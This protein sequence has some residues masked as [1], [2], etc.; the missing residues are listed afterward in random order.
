MK[1]LVPMLCLFFACPGFANEAA[2]QAQL[3]E[4]QKVTDALGEPD[5]E[6]Q[7][8][9]YAVQIARSTTQSLATQFSSGNFQSMQA[10]I[11][12]SS[13]QLAAL[14]N[15]FR[16]ALN[17]FNIELEKHLQELNEARIEEL[18]D[19]FARLRDEIIAAKKP[20][21]LDPLLEEIS[22]RSTDRSYGSGKLNQE[23]SNLQ[24]KVSQ[25]SAIVSEWQNYLMAES[26]N[27]GPACKRALE[28][29]SRY[30][31]SN[32]LIPR[33]HVLRLLNPQVSVPAPTPPKPEKGADP[34]SAADAEAFTPFPEIEKALERGGDWNEI[35]KLL[36]ALPPAQQADQRIS[37]FRSAIEKLITLSALDEA[38]SFLELIDAII[39]ANEEA[40]ILKGTSFR[41]ARDSFLMKSLQR[42]YAE[43]LKKSEIKA[44]SPAQLLDQ[45][46][47]H[48]LDLR[49]WAL[50]SKVLSDQE[51]LA[52][53]DRFGSE[54]IYSS[55]AEALKALARAE[56][57]AS[58]EEIELAIK[59]YRLAA[60]KSS[61]ARVF[62]ASFEGL[63]A[64]KETKPEAFE[65]AEEEAR[66]DAAIQRAK[67]KSYL[68]RDSRNRS[69][70][71]MAQQVGKDG[72][73][74]DKLKNYIQKLLRDEMPDIRINFLETILDESSDTTTREDKA[75]H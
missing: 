42:H 14:P 4:L 39:N 61:D 58:A 33:S 46:T 5:A 68:V 72:E 27:D 12:Q 66:E 41:A 29:V 7:K 31:S 26:I 55:D 67:R 38:V 57:A 32:P 48:Y 15:D 21:D 3:K 11:Q 24:Q 25:S 19:F 71:S 17:A 47:S 9:V 70:E 63:K 45:L 28:N 10:Q 65:K 69:M 62:R 44:T 16:K 18:E 23:I 75:E 20:E 37:E 49:E 50:A 73:I 36:A 64:L 59:Y 43:T 6:N 8:E 1:R 34:T 74:P 13:S 40:W 56:A 53:L 22:Q 51:A 52:R 60:E 2:L 54:R 30:L 35:A